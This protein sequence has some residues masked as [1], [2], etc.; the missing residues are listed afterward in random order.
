MDVEELAAAKLGVVRKRADIGDV[1]AQSEL[2]RRLL[3]R[4][5]HEEAL[6]WFRAAARSGEP[7]L[8]MELGIVLFW[9]LGAHREGFKWIRRAAEQGDVGAQYFLAAEL[10]TGENVRK[11]LRGGCSLVSSRSNER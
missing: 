1:A 8:Q 7:E 2:A 6:R 11:N 3:G 9:D 4:K 10:A 5:K